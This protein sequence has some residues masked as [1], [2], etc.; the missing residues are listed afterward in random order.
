MPVCLRDERMASG[1]GRLRALLCGCTDRLRA[2][3]T[4][5]HPLALFTA[6]WTR[7]EGVQVKPSRWGEAGKESENM[8]KDRVPKDRKRREEIS[9][10][11]EVTMFGYVKA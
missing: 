10:K 3:C 1:S 9:E 7:V 8:K 2:V 4:L 6:K 5:T 11:K